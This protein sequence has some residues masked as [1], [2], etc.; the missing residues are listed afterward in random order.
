[1]GECLILKRGGG[2]YSDDLTATRSHV[3]SG[4]TAVTQDSDDDIAT[5]TMPNRGAVNQALNAGGAYTIPQGYHNGSGKVSANSLASQTPADAVAAN[6]TSGKTAWVNGTKITGNGQDNQT[7]Y[8]NGYHA[9]GSYTLPDISIYVQNGE[10]GTYNSNLYLPL[11]G[12]SNVSFS[13]YANRY[14]TLTGTI[15]YQDGSSEVI[16]NQKGE[17]IKQPVSK[18][19]SKPAKYIH[20]KLANGSTVA[21]YVI[22]NFTVS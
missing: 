3:L 21:L 5:G 10:A 11:Q 13:F 18:S 22:Y 9:G 20:L 12:G 19:I 1:M 7:F 17:V 16:V 4:Y 6:L 14:G 15:H 2:I 8:Q